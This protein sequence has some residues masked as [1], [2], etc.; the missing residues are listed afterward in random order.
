LLPSL[1]AALRLRHFSIHTERAYV[2]W[3]RRFVRFCGNRHPTVCDDRDVVAFLEHLVR[4]RAVSASTQNQALAAVSFLYRDVL[5]QPLGAL[6]AVVRARG[7]VRVPTVLE[8]EEVERVLREMRGVP[9]L[10][11]MVMYGTGLRL[12]EAL[13]LRLKDL[14]LARQTVVVRDGKGGTDRRTVLPERLVGVLTDRVAELRQAHLRAVQRG[15]GHV[16]L[17]RA[18]A[19]KL[20]GAVRDWRWSWLFPAAREVYAREFGRR[21]RFPVHATT[22]QR[23]IA[24]AAMASGINK[25][26]TAHTFRHSFATHLLRSGADI[27]TVQELL[28]HRDVTTTMGYLHVLARGVAVRSPLDRLGSV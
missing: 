19:V 23:A 18:L 24:A 13:S 3:V 2:L 16:A 25:R 12:G 4:T 14:D 28:G 1:R 17:P 27:R 5:Q 11:V 8:P 9:R 26:V 22:V 6:P 20:P 7:R 21:V 15:G 10:V